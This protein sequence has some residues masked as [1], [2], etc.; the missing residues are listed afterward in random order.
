VSVLA[1]DPVGVY[2]TKQE[3]APAVVPATNVHG[4]VTNVPVP[5]VMKLTVPVGVL[6]VPTSMS[7]TVAVH[8]VDVPTLTDAGKH[9]TEV[10]TA[11]TKVNRTSLVLPS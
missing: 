11:R 2:M 1:V 7:V 3:A 10:V 4:D 5:L 6:E 8:F 9:D